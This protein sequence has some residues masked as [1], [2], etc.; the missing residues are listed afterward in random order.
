MV[1]PI[2]KEI[3]MGTYLLQRGEHLLRFDLNPMLYAPGVYYLSVTQR[4]RK[5]AL[6]LVIR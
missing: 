5:V 4:E 2:G 1:N 3:S 6:K